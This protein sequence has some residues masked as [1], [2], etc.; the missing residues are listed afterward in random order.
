MTRRGVAAI[1]AV[2]IAVMTATVAGLRLVRRRLAR[3]AV[4]LVRPSTP[5][6]T[7]ALAMPGDARAVG[8]AGFDPEECTEESESEYE[9]EEEANFERFHTLAQARAT[10]HTAVIMQGGDGAQIYLTVPVKYVRCDE[11]ALRELLAAI[12]RLACDRPH[13]AAMSL[14]LAPVGS[15]VFGGLGGG[16]IVD[17]VWVHPQLEVDVLPTARDVILGRMTAADLRAHGVR[18]RE[19]S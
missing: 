9:A 15:G 1:F 8:H 16:S 7:P 6:E 12:D 3:S 5:L 2:F 18:S 11:A 13:E 4:R 19:T 10:E 14:E 17:G